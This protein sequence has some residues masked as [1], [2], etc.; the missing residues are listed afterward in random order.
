MNGLWAGGFLLLLL[1]IAAPAASA[2]VVLGGEEYLAVSVD[3][4]DVAMKEVPLLGVVSFNCAV[5]DRSRDATLESPNSNGLSHMTSIEVDVLPY[6]MNASDPNA[7]TRP[8][9]GWSAGGGGSFETRGGETKD[10]IVTVAAGG[11]TVDNYARVRITATTRALNGSAAVDQ[12]DLLVQLAPFHAG[13]LVLSAPPIKAGQFEVVT[14]PLEVRNF[15]TYPEV[16]RLNTT[17][18]EGWMASVPPRLVMQPK[19]IRTLNMTIVTPHRSVYELGAP[20]TIRVSMHSE[21]E[22]A[23]VYEGS[24]VVTVSGPYFPPYWWPALF[25]GIVGAAVVAGSARERAILRRGERGPAR[26][27]RPSPKEA[28]LLAALRARDREAWKARMAVYGATYV[29]RRRVWKEHRRSEVAAERA[30]R[31][32]SHL[33]AKERRAKEKELAKKRR[34][35]ERAQR[36]RDD[37]ARAVAAKAE[38]R[39]AKARKKQAKIDAKLA[40]RQ[41]KA[42]AKTAAKQAKQRARLEKALAKKRKELEATARKRAKELD[43]ARKKAGKQ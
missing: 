12:T 21:S 23:V 41:A 26:R 20:G 43:K 8:P 16:F 32:E 17:A 25:L 28:A 7:T 24:V 38:A 27:P 30:E 4:N 22:P 18:P 19:E 33:A 1:S 35:L 14:Y 40:K 11:A 10:F 29:E 34:A 31:R 6:V 39:E 3:V 2:Q 15:N 42:D 13:Q 9:A 36:R 5:T 37:A